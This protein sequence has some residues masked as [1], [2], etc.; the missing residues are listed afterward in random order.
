MHFYVYQLSFT[1]S[2]KKKIQPIVVGHL[3]TGKNIKKLF[4][5]LS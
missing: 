2:G 1:F 3:L 4:Q 5:A